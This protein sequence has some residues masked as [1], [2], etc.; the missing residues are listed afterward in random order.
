M[1]IMIFS[2]FLFMATL[3][4][5]E[6]PPP[7]AF[8]ITRIHYDGGGDWYADPSSLP[9]LLAYLKDHTIMAINPLEKRAKIGDDIFSRSS[10]LYITGHGNIK[11][12]DEEA[13]N[14][15]EQMTEG[16][17]KPKPKYL[18]DRGDEVRVIDGPFNNFNGVVDE[19]SPEKGK[20]R[21]L[22]SIFGRSTPVELDFVHVAKI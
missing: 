4:Y 18:F 13:Q 17:L 12:S 3:L 19:V 1:K 20:V 7:G 22:V 6:S 11:F 16:A 5:S 2:I 15:V 14:I 21:V 10:Y 8:S 9:N